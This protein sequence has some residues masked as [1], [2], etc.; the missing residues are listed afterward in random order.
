M[1]ILFDKYLKKILISFLSVIFFLLNSNI[2]FAKEYG[3]NNNNFENYN[4][5]F[6]IIPK[7]IIIKVDENR[8]WQINNQKIILDLIKKKS[9]SSKFTDAYIDPKLKKKRFNA[10][11]NVIYDNNLNCTYLGRVKQHGDFDDHIQLIQK[12]GGVAQS[13]N[14]H[15]KNGNINGVTKF[16]LYSVR[17]TR[18]PD[19]IF[20]SILLSKLGFMAPRTFYVETEVNGLKNIL[21]F[22][23]KIAKE[24]LEVNKKREGPIYKVNE[25]IISKDNKLFFLEGGTFAKQININ[26]A[27]KG[28]NHLK[29]SKE[30]LSKINNFFLENNRINEIIM[31]ENIN[32][33]NKN[34]AF[35]N[36]EQLNLMN[37]FNITLIAMNGYHALY[38]NNRRFYWNSIN[39]IFEPIYYDG[40]IRILGDLDLKYIDNVNIGHRGKFLDAINKTQKKLKLINI[41]KF[42]QKLQSQGYVE[43]I[44][45]TKRKFSKINENL[46]LLKEYFTNKTIYENVNLL[47][48]ND[49]YKNILKIINVLDDYQ[50]KELK[51][52]FEVEDYFD[53]YFVKCVIESKK[54]FI[55]N[56]ENY[57]TDFSYDYL[58]GRINKN[59]NYF[60][61]GVYKI[62]DFD[63]KT[64][65]MFNFPGIIKSEVFLL[66]DTKIYYDQSIDFK[67]DKKNKI[68]NINQLYPEARVL[69]FGGK[70]NNYTINFEGNKNLK[71]KNSKFPF[72]TNG[73]TGC[74][75]FLN[76]KFDNLKIKII[77]ANCEDALNI[78]NGEGS[79]EKVEISDSLSDAIDL[80]FSN[81]N[82]NELLINNS[83]NDCADFSYGKHK[84]KFAKL[85]N[86]GDKA[87][88]IGE[89]TNA[90]IDNIIISYSSTGIAVKDGSEVLINNSSISNTE[91]CI[92][93][94]NKKQEFYGGKLN[95]LNFE[96]LESQSRINKDKYSSIT[97]K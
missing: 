59:Q 33:N 27:K 16:I 90:N 13:L 9:K 30:G 49:L 81:I 46:L 69:F 63:L 62:D 24:L 34:L 55:C 35:E 12:V 6:N 28:K 14:I 15:L 29:I 93:S 74:L 53:R 47:K 23:E 32:L 45:I 22:Q 2:L 38:D 26:W 36:Q 5:I 64:I 91:L 67:H 75:N 54:K 7:K 73:L 58:E 11:V 71:F 60:Y 50:H 79:L 95:I 66:G 25:D 76:T 78:I 88:S 89:K 80:D 77:K 37:I 96:C 42:S 18:T 56:K 48:T 21:M 52:I 20:A 44:D 84:L 40:D 4:E 83:G 68:I 19:E 86:C 97:I 85:S 39:K 87:L 3:C 70:I 41:E 17:S 10:E 92:S 51:L 61:L 57:N 72:D 65:K 94:Y 1:L 8:K 82:I 31:T 43:N